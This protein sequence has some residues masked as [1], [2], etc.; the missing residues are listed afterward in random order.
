[1]AIS[2]N[3]QS[4][5]LK[6]PSTSGHAATSPTATVEGYGRPVMSFFDRLKE[7]D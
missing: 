5:P 2:P 1:M 6:E 7:L 3:S 4:I